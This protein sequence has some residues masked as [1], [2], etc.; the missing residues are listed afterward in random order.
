[1]TNLQIKLTTEEK[2]KLREASSSIYLKMGSFIRTIALQ[3]ADEILSNK[4]CLEEE[5]E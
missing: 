3:K 1:M 4:Y 5:E 2:E